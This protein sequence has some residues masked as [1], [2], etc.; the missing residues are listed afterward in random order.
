MN[1]EIYRNLFEDSASAMFILQPETGGI[2]DA[3]KA[4]CRFYGYKKSELK[5]MHIQDINMLSK[6]QISKIFMKVM[7]RRQKHFHFKHRLADGEIK[8]VEVF[9]GPISV[10]RQKLLYSIVN[11]IS[12]RKYIENQIQQEKKFSESLISSLPGV[13]YVFD[14][15]GRFIRWNKNFE[16]V[17]GYSDNQIKEMNP[18]DF[19][20]SVDKPRVRQ[21]IEEVFHKGHANVEAGLS[22]VSGKIIPY[23]FTGYRFAQENLNYLVGVGL[24]I[25]DR[26]KTEIE[27]E[28]LIRKLRETLSEVKQLSGLLPI[29]ASCKNI[30]DDKG[31]WN[32]IELYIKKHSEAEFSHGICPDCAKRLYPGLGLKGKTDS[33][34][35]DKN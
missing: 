11:D 9:S 33:G 14:Q 23:L 2:L 29:C 24:D 32:K 35:P 6:E 22:T 8:E 34:K 10:G 15:L 16:A 7:N 25:S 31:Y 20:A 26:V 12:E 27:K 19:I 28:N 30:R 4:A 5:G 18:L 1:D 13:M 21:T 3:N 17:S